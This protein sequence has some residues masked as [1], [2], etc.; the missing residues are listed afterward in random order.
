MMT[1]M[2]LCQF[3]GEAILVCEPELCMEVQYNGMKREMQVCALCTL[4]ESLLIP[5]P[6]A[7]RCICT[8]R[9]DCF[10]NQK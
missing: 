7:M 9:T 1:G 10:S 2:R 4:S 5:L 6:H 3:L 8:A